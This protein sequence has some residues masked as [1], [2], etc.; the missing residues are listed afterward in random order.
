MI[1]TALRV[2]VTAAT[3]TVAAL[4]VRH[5]LTPEA[6][7]LLLKQF[8][9]ALSWLPLGVVVPLLPALVVVPTVTVAAVVI[10]LAWRRR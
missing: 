3:T 1:T 2:A 5:F 4:V 9:S 6:Q 8:G 10:Y 7:W